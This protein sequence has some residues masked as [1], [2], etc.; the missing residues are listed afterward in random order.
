MVDRALV[1]VLA[2]PLAHTMLSLV[3]Q[4]QL[5]VHK[6]IICTISQVIAS[7]AVMRINH[8][9]LVQP[10]AHTMLNYSLVS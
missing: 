2:I 10:L 9:N 5:I 7:V 1:L 6:Y 8:L 3:S 4:V